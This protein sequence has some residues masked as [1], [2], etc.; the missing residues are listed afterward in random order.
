MAS[1][2]WALHKFCRL[3]PCQALLGDPS[4]LSLTCPRARVT[5]S[6]CPP[7][8]RIFTM[9]NYFL[10]TTILL[11][12]LSG[13]APILREETES[14]KRSETTWASIPLEGDKKTPTLLLPDP[15]SSSGL[16]LNM[17]PENLPE[18][19]VDK[20]SIWALDFLWWLYK[21]HL[22]EKVVQSLLSFWFQCHF[23]VQ[24]SKS[25]WID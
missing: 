9:G 15:G 20:E 10:F 14:R 12:S 3:I 5:E 21:S 11:A 17:L 4:L 1:I 8:S 2:C 6:V 7:F 18:Y 23:T 19:T 24:S 25:F 13:T 22:W 16:L